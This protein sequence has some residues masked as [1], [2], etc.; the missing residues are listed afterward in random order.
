MSEAYLRSTIRNKQEVLRG[1]SSN[2]SEA[3]AAISRLQSERGRPSAR[4]GDELR[5]NQEIDREIDK[6]RRTVSSSE[7][8]IDRQRREID[9]LEKELRSTYGR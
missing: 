1:L 6:H 5:R 8:E 9:G 4:P 7:R 2:I 3:Q